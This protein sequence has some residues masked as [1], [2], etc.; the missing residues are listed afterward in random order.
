MEKTKLISNSSSVLADLLSRYCGHGKH[1]SVQEMADACGCSI[2]TVYLAQHGTAPGFDL[3]WCM[4][5]QLPPEAQ[6]AFLAALGL[7]GARRIDGPAGCFRRLHSATTRLGHIMAR[8][9]EDGRID[10]REAAELQKVHLPALQ[11][12]ASR[13]MGPQP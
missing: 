7:H 3:G 1:M 8:M 5:Q 6:T 2:N 12:E 10:Y 4:V 11:T 9:F 13:C